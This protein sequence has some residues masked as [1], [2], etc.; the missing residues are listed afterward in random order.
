MSLSLYKNNLITKIIYKIW[1]LEVKAREDNVSITWSDWKGD[2]DVHWETKGGRDWRRY[3]Q[4]IPT[5]K[6][7]EVKKPHAHVLCFNSIGQNQLT[8]FNH[9]HIPRN[10]LMSI[11]SLSFTFLDCHFMPF[12]VTQVHATQIIICSL[13]YQWVGGEL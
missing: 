4:C 2:G 12:I 6:N 1:R 9:T 8:Y 13:T 11:L 3:M 5:C 7:N 10:E